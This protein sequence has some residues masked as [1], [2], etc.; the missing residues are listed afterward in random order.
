MNK[1]N[2]CNLCP[3]N[4][5][6]ESNSKLGKV[7]VRIDSNENIVDINKVL[8]KDCYVKELLED[9]QRDDINDRRNY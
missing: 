3:S 2:T 1:E 9:R 5:C 6:L 4:H 7:R 8:I